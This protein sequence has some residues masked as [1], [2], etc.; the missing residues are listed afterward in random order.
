MKT[1]FGNWFCTEDCNGGTCYELGDVNYD[2][3]INI[4]DVVNIVNIILGITP[5]SILSDVNSDQLTN[6]IDVVLIIEFILD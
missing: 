1:V 4:V 2:S 6:I 5:Y 3:N